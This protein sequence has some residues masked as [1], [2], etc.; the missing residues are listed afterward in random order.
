MAGEVEKQ[1]RSTHVAR[2]RAEALTRLEWNGLIALYQLAY[3]GQRFS[4]SLPT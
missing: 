3:M 2:E 4:F 1:A